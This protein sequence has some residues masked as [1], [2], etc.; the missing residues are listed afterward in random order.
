MFLIATGIQCRAGIFMCLVCSPIV[1]LAARL[2]PFSYW[3]LVFELVNS[4]KLLICSEVSGLA[5]QPCRFPSAAFLWLSRDLGGCVSE[6]L[7]KHKLH[8]KGYKILNPV[9]ADNFQLAYS[10]CGVVLID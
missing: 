1:G 3:K 6:F 4:G 9:Y 2:N 10:S 5:S 8:Q 7:P